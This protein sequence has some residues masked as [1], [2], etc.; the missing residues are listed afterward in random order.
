MYENFSYGKKQGDSLSRFKEVNGFQR[1][2][3]P[4]YYV[5]LTPIGRAAFRLGLHH[6]IV[7]HLPESVMARLRKLRTAWY[8]RK[9]HVS[10]DVS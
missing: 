10:L 1:M 7:D 2:D 8:T 5:A 3:L 9:L 4:R 6:R